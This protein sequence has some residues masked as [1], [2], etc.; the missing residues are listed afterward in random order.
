[1]F[2]FVF[3][4]KTNLLHIGIGVK[5]KHNNHSS[6]LVCYTRWKNYNIGQKQN[7]LL[8]LRLTFDQS[9]KPSGVLGMG[10]ADDF[11]ASPVLEIYQRRSMRIVIQMTWQPIIK[12][13]IDASMAWILLFDKYTL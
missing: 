10:S 13:N 11:I 2:S 8:K 12:M 9:I 7:D 3:F 1:M 6:T 5:L 4:N